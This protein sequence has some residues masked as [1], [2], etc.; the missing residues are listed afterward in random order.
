[1]LS[2][3]LN[4]LK[5]FGTHGLYPGEKF[6]GGQFEV[7]VIVQF[8]PRN[9]PVRYMDET[10]DYTVVYQLVKSVMDEPAEL[11]ETLATESVHRLLS[12]YGNAEYV[13]VYVRKLNAPIEGFEGEVGAHFEWRRHS[14]SRR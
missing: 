14:G 5:F 2:I 10:I 6:T 8:E 13:S 3:K 7:D 9:I 12:A 1:M 11:L 4:N